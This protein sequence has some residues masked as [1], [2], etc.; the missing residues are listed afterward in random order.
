MV[1]KFLLQHQQDSLLVFSG[2]MC[3][4]CETVHASFHFPVKDDVSPTINWQLLKYDLIII[5]EISMIP[6]II[7]KHI[8]K[9]L[10]VLLFHPVI[11][12]CGDSS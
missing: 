3:Q 6:D 11:M 1:Q 5:D 4:D 10:T 2:L 12:V 9:T 7:F 8:Q